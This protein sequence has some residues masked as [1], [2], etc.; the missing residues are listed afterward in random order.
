MAVSKHF[1]KP[2]YSFGSQSSA[3]NRI[4]EK[5]Y[6][7]YPNRI[8]A[9]DVTTQKEL[10]VDKVFNDNNFKTRIKLLP[11]SIQE[12]DVKNLKP[13]T[14]G[15]KYP[16][17]SKQNIQKAYSEWANGALVDTDIEILGKDNKLYVIRQNYDGDSQTL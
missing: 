5:L 2:L 12:G 13:Q 10:D 1:G 15:T 4:W 7:Q 9:V 6:Q 11:E 16:L 8:K 3:G 17:F 14:K